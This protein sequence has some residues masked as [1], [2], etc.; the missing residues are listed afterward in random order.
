MKRHCNRLNEII[1]FLK[2]NYNDYYQEGVI[3]LP[4]EQKQDKDQ[5]H[6]MKEDLIYNRINPTFIKVFLVVKKTK[7]IR[8]NSEDEKVKFFIHLTI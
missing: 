4:D 6:N 3:A 1:K 7:E 8:C 2:E 5:H